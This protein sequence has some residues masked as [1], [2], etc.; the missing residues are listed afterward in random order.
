MSGGLC[1]FPEIRAI[2]NDTQASHPAG[3]VLAFAGALSTTVA[4]A[5]SNDY[6]WPW[7]LRPVVMETAARPDAMLAAFNDANGNLGVVST[8]GLTISYQLNEE[9]TPVLRLAA[10]HNNAPG[11]ALDGS[12]FANPLLGAMH[13]RDW[14]PYKLALFAGASVPL[15]TGGGN[16]PDVKAARANLAA[17]TARPADDTMFAVNYLTPIVGAD[18]AWVNHGFT[19]Q[20]EVTLQELVRVR[21]AKSASSL[22]R[23][24]T[25]AA[26]AL[27]L[28]YFIG[29]HFSLGGDLRYERW[30]SHPTARNTATS[31][32]VPIPERDMDVVTTAVG[33]RVHFR[34]G[35]HSSVHPGFS[36]LRGFDGRAF[37]APLVTAQTTAVQFDIP[38]E[39]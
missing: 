15:G 28:G 36:V 21:G 14:G 5:A 32:R 24:R 38:V 25:N 4:R 23:F 16:E 35:E 18:F 9:V 33:A 17:A 7:Q 29:S 11:A 3:D 22:D 20:V 27:H 8:T 30:L 19:A 31:E 26:V 1:L 10:V 37:S 13:A 39:F 6:S 34:L 2:E 12:S